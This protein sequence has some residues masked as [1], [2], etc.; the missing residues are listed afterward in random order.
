MEREFKLALADADAAARLRRAL[1]AARSTHVRQ[2]NHFF[3]TRPGALRALRLA[4]RLRAE[5]E[6]WFLT[7]KGPRVQEAG[8]LAARPEEELELEPTRATEILRGV[9][10]PLAEFPGSSLVEQA[11]RAVEGQELVHLGAFENERERIGP[12]RLGALDVPVVLELDRTSYPDGVAHE[13]EVELPDGLTAEA[14]ER[15]L[16]ALWQRL[17][18]PWRAGANKAARFFRLLDARAGS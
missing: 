7:L 11:R 2:T 13:L 6:R 17:D 4:L 16:R 14:L 1:P 8:G 10:A 9:R 12:L 18:L 3:D 15:E 5:E